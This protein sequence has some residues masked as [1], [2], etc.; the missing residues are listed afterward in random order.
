M[1]TYNGSYPV[2]YCI[3][4]VANGR[5]AYEL[6]QLKSWDRYGIIQFFNCIAKM[7]FRYGRQ[8]AANAYLNVVFVSESYD[9]FAKN[10][11]ISHEL[12]ISPF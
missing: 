8:L 11:F 6:E 10:S 4:Q 5:P 12:D 3:R 7:I 2:I 9:A 1:Y